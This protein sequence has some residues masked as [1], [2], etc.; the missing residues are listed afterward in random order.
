MWV[1]VEIIFS[2]QFDSVFI[3]VKKKKSKN[4]P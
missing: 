1:G 3:G 4:L 2:L